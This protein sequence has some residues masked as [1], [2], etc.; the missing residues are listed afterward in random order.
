ML[1]HEGE[2]DDTFAVG[3]LQ[4]GCIKPFRIVEKIGPD[5]KFE[6]IEFVFFSGG[7]PPVHEQG[8]D[9]ASFL[10]P[11]HGDVS[12]KT[13][14]PDHSPALEVVVVVQTDL[15]VLEKRVLVDRAVRIEQGGHVCVLFGLIYEELPVSKFD[16]PEF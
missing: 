7:Q 15:V 2:K 13:V 10:P 3:V 5:G 11:F 6:R 9:S 12:Q 4:F 1:L 8:G 16:S 14:L